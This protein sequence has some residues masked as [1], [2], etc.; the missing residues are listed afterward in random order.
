NRDSQEY[1]VDSYAP[2]LRVRRRPPWSVTGPVLQP[3]AQGGRRVPTC[4][5]TTRHWSAADA[6]SWLSIFLTDPVGSAPAT[7]RVH[8]V[9]TESGTPA[10]AVRGGAQRRESA[11]D[12]TINSAR[13]GDERAQRN[14][15][16]EWA[17]RM[18]LISQQR[19]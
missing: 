13:F 12:F 4:T 14:I 6:A 3:V 10:K 18:G 16:T 2:A 19:S 8:R 11:T 15:S 9:R 5:G 1:T 17:D 7:R